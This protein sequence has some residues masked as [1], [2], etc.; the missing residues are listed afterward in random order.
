LVRRARLVAGGSAGV[1]AR[2]DLFSATACATLNAAKDF[3]KAHGLEVDGEIG[4]ETAKAIDRALAELRPATAPAIVNLGDRILRIG[5]T[6]PI[7][8]AVQ[9][10]LMRLGYPLE[11]TGNFGTATEAAVRD[12]QIRHGLKVD[13]EV[14]PEVAKTLDGALA[15]LARPTEPSATAGETSAP[16]PLMQPSGAGS[17]A[18]LVSSSILGLGDEGPTVQ[19]VQGAL[20]KLG[21]AIKGTGYFGGA[22]E[23]AVTDFQEQRGLEVDGEVGAET[24]R[25]I[26]L[27]LGVLPLAERPQDAQATRVPGVDTRPL[28][29]VEGL[30]WLNI[31]EA[32]G[33]ADNPDIL[34]WAKEEGGEIAAEYKHD[35]IPWCS[36]FANMVLTKV[37]LKGT[38][39]L[40]ALDWNEWGQALPGPTIGA[41]APM[42]RAGGGHIVIVVGRDNWGNLMCLGGNQDD[43]VNIKPFP[44]Q[45]PLSFRWPVDVPPPLKAD[46]GLLPLMGSDGRVSTKE[47]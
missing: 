34:E 42:K 30:K 16:M 35:S 7:V 15:A 10:G 37:G 5:D 4:P 36:L 44:A 21:Y 6:G 17:V 11:G 41:F 47:S 40:W 32:P 27:A 29:V 20:A 46:F 43:A 38:K 28:W 12:F 8:Q 14:G 45:R 39:T 1:N 31:A 9:L 24:A 33:E 13:G 25:A 18:D 3:Q 22:T 23:A 2:L 19:A 26:D